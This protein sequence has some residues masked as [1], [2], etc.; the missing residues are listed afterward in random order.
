MSADDAGLE[1]GRARLDAI[2]AALVELLAERAAVV[3]ELAAWKAARG[4][5]FRDPAREAE[6]L[7]RVRALAREHGLDEAAVAAV[8]AAVVGRRLERG[9]GAG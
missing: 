6:T 2:D 5:G 7:A 9:E 4:R 8:F 3:A 1:E